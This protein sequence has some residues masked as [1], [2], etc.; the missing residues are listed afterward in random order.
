[1]MINHRGNYFHRVLCLSTVIILLTSVRLGRIPASAADEIV[2]IGVYE[3]APKIFIAES[4][5]PAGIFIDV[6]EDIAKSEGWNLH[7]VPG[8]WGEGLDRLEKGEIDL[9]PDVAY[10][11]DRE[12]IFAYHKVPVLTSWYRVYAR[13]GSGI[14]TI[15]DLDGKRISVLERSVQREAFVRL[16]EGFG[17]TTTIISVPDYRSIFEMVERNEADAAITNRFYGLM[18]AKKFGLKDTPV[19]FHPSDL[20][21]AAPKGTH[22]K[23]LNAIDAHLAVL[24]RDPLSIY[25]Q[26]LKRWSFEDGRFEFP[27]WLQLLG[28]FLILAALLS[29]AGSFVLKRQVNSRTRALRQSEEQFRLIMGSIV[30]LVAVLDLDGRRLYSS[31]SYQG[32]LGDPAKLRGSSSFDEVHPEDRARV[33]QAFYETV[34]TGVGQ[35]L[36]YRLIDREGH[37]RCIESEGSVIR[38]PQGRVSQVVIVS[39]DITERKKI[40][41]RLAKSEQRYRELVEQANSIILR[42]TSDGQLTFLNEFGQRFFGYSAEEILGRHVIG[43]I[44][45]T[46]ESN[47][48]DLRQLMEQICAD[49]KAFEQNVNE[50]IRR[51]GERVWVSWTNRI[52]PDAEGRVAE[53]LSVG[54]DITER[55]RAEEQIHRLHE[56]LQRHAAELER[57]VAERTAELAVAR[58]HAEEAD[59]L[60]S[61]F[62]ATMSHELRTP[63]NSII[64]FTGILLMGLVGPLTHEQEK[65]LTMVQDSA[66]HL[67]E[68]INDVLDISKIEAGQLELARDPFDMRTTI[69]KSIEK[70]TPLAEQ[71]GLAVTTVI[72]PLVGQVVGDRR[73]TEQILI[74]L[75]SNA[76]KFTERGGVRV[77]SQVEDG[78]LVTRVIDSGIG[79]RPEDL[80]TLFKPFRQVD[81]G[82]T[83]RYEGTGL[84]LSICKRLVESMGGRIRVES[85][86]GRGSRF[87]FTLPLERTPT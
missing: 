70:I 54:T 74:N 38:D 49:P 68:L 44:V 26:S 13:K 42:W 2:K 17:L 36:E 19:I 47:G 78:W 5:Q 43:T 79:I 46:T 15:L 4:G 72:A 30:D 24:K 28:A 20:F 66:H 87:V 75:L 14:Q 50:N 62:L 1:M 40:G 7:Y 84:G 56:D 25:Y 67:L 71:K 82:I 77:E 59:R 48:R 10:S 64:G 41:E 51:N 21:F 6:I 81:A 45:P 63:L 35:R 9:M 86:W 60:K 58:D 29:V 31:P 76:V 11:A 55:R 52:V 37:A 12:R 34:R 39:R 61:A 16:S 23:L 53:I 80:D 57:R 65:Q 69:Q 18:H 33:K 8:T 73:R 3:N 27:V 83:R 22:Q 32:I 85:E